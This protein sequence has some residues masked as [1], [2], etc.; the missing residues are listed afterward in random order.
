M[1]AHIGVDEA[2]GRVHTVVNPAA[3][4]SEVSQVAS[5]LHGEESRVGADAGYVGAAK[6]PEV[7]AKPA[8]TGQTI[9]CHIAGSTHLR[10]IKQ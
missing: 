10:P 3:H 4:E 9:G 8:E 5:L 1:K 7:V 2:S 6:R